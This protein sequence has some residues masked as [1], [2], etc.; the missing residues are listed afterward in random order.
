MDWE[1]GLSSTV[2]AC[3]HKALSSNPSPTKKKKNRIG[4]N[5]TFNKSLLLSLGGGI[6]LQGLLKSSYVLSG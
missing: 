6:T 1:H 4:Q 2:P 5:Q 3:K